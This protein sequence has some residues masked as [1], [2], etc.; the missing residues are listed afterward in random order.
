[1]MA[2]NLGRLEAI[3]VLVKAGALRHYRI[4]WAAQNGHAKVRA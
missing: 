3:E 4:H 2:V 1:M